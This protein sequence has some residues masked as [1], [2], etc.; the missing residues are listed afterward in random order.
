MAWKLKRTWGE[1]DGWEQ[2]SF[3]TSYFRPKPTPV[4]SSIVLDLSLLSPTTTCSF[5]APPISINLSHCLF[6]LNIA[7]RRAGS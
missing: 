3:V 5:H 1:R 4:P 7:A 2:P 6:F